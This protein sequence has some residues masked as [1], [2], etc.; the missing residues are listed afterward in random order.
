MSCR[1]ATFLTFGSMYSFVAAESRV[2][3]TA[4]VLAEK[5]YQPAE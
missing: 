5:S 4:S 1:T 2:A 3:L